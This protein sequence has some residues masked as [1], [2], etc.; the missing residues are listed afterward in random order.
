LIREIVRNG[1]DVG[2]FLPPPVE[3]RLRERLRPSTSS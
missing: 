2:S 1:G 3:S